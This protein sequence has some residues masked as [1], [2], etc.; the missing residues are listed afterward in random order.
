MTITRQPIIA[1]VGHVDHGKSSILEKIKG[2]SIT[3]HEPGL[4]TQKITA[5]S[6]AMGNMQNF[7]GDILKQLK[8][9]LTIPG[10]L[11]I[12]TPGHAAFTNLRKRGGSIADM[13]ILV[14]DINEGVKPQT[15]EAVEILKNCKTPFVIALNKIDLIGGWRSKKDLGLIQNISSQSENIKTA[16]DTKMY[17][18]VGRLYNLGITAERFDRVDDY[19]KQ[20]AIIP[21][22]AKTLEG[23]PELLMT[24]SGLTKRYFEKK[25]E[26]KLNAKAKGT[27]LEVKEDK[28]LGIVLDVIVYDGMLNINDIIIIGGIEKPITTKVSSI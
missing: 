19:T 15:I 17:E 3:A 26:I 10:I 24:I 21:V 13:A 1:L 11:L 12:D 20:I 5:Y 27:V 18:I 2:I 28:N 22:S 6:I 16:L 23:W 25:L 14:I 7:C 8:V 9:K 4:I